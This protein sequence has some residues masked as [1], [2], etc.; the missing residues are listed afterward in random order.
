M[1]RL[2]RNDAREHGPTGKNPVS[3]FELRIRDQQ[4]DLGLGLESAAMLR[5]QL[6]REWLEGSRKR[7]EIAHHTRLT[8]PRVCMG[9]M[10]QILSELLQRLETETKTF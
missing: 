8:N 7:L 5:K 1:S 9:I 2:P 3:L 4:V 10:L 6:S